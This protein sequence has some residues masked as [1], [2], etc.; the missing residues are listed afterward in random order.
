MNTVASDEAV[1]IPTDVTNHKIRHV[2]HRSTLDRILEGQRK[3]K[4]PL[5]RKEFYRA[6]IK[7]VP[8]DS[9]LHP[10]LEN[11]K[12]QLVFE[13]KDT[14]KYTYPTVKPGHR[15]DFLL[16][17]D[18]SLTIKKHT[19]GSSGN[20]HYSMNVNLKLEFN[21]VKRLEYALRKLIDVVGNSTSI[22]S[23]TGSRV[24]KPSSKK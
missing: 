12:F 22:I 10:E 2:Y 9:R 17:D 8:R 23:V 15:L 4:S 7:R 3:A 19:G 14:H 20:R 11:K 5:T 1:Y 24:V 21:E 13:M 6:D 18:N 16:S